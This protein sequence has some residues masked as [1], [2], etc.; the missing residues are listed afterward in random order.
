MMTKKQFDVMVAMAESAEPLSQRELAQRTGHSIGTVNKIAS[1]LGRVGWCAAGRLTE[2]GLLRL[3]DFRVRRAVILAAGFGSRLVPVTLNTPKPLVRIHGK[4]LIDTMLDAIVAAGIEE[5]YIV[6][7]YLGE[8]F[9]QLLNKYPMVRLLENPAYNETNNISS[10]ICASAHMH[11]AYVLDADL[12]LKNPALIRRY[13]YA[14][15]Y[16]GVPMDKTDDWCFT[17]KNGVISGIALGGTDCYGWIGISYWTETDGRRLVAYM[18]EVYQSPGGKERFW[19]QVAL[20][21]HSDQFRVEVRP[22][23]LD[24]VVEIDTYSELKALDKSYDV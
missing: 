12:Y 11:N 13:E 1:E 3:E 6:R 9:D 7:G 18:Q 16:L 20:Q 10:A 24:D 5:I 8:Q 17:V 4:R 22:C 23:T 21:Y 2:A 15:N 19:D 14:T